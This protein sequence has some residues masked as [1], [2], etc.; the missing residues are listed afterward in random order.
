MEDGR[1]R[2]SS[3]TALA[4]GLS[5]AGHPF[6]LAPLTVGVMTRSVFW[7][8]VIAASTAVP[9][10]AI[11]ARNVRRGAWSDF[12][13]S[14]HEQRSGLYHAGLPLMVLSALILWFLG[15]APALLRAT[16]AATAMFVAGLIGNRWL[17]I[18]MH[19]MTA[20]FCAVFLV[21]EHPWL[22]A[23]VVPF[24]VAIAWSRRHLQRHTW[25]EI[26]IGLA[27]GTAAAVAAV[28]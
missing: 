18:S 28:W 22:A 6:L 8:S 17:K 16:A 24:V 13:V 27:L 7:T 10:L 5:V 9:L 14:R 1:S 21:R 26:G 11:I 3:S 23:I 12:D 20:A 15:A 2:L 19:M 25:L 4:R